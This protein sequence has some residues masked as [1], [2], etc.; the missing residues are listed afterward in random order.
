MEHLLKLLKS[1]S[2]SGI[3]SVSLAQIGNKLIALSCCLNSSAPWIIDLGAS[4]HMTSSSHLFKSYSPCSENEKVRITDSSFSSIAGKGLIKISERID[5]KSVLHVPK[6]ACNL[7]VLT[8]RGFGA[9]GL[10]NLRSLNV[11]LHFS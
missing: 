10:C 5:L 3:P 6:L 7:F 8:L 9:V 1:N 11:F 2:S 4:D